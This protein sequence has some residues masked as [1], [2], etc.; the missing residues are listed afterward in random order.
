MR[1]QDRQRVMAAATHIGNARAA[2]KAEAAAPPS[3][4]R[5]AAARA[6]ALDVNAA[7]MKA[8]GY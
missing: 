1:D 4:A 8:Y 7:G 2:A 6:R 5:P 3:P